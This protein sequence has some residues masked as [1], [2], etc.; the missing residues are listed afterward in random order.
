MFHLKRFNYSEIKVKDI[1]YDWM[2][3]YVIFFRIFQ[4]ASEGK[5]KEGS[6]RETRAMDEGIPRLG[7]LVSTPA[8]Y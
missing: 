1:R 3:G 4:P 6:E 8:T 5:G 7:V 2:T